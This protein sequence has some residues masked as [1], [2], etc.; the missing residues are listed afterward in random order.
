[1]ADFHF[2]I[3]S[4]I[5]MTSQD[6]CFPKSIAKPPQKK[7]RSYTL[8]HLS[9]V[10][11]ALEEICISCK[12]KLYWIEFSNGHG[13]FSNTGKLQE[14]RVAFKNSLRAYE[15]SDYQIKRKYIKKSNQFLIREGGNDD[16]FRT[17]RELSP[18]ERELVAPMITNQ[19]VD[20][21][22]SAKMLGGGPNSGQ[23]YREAID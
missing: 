2:N 22:N 8:R 13:G 11:M 23:K 21:T 6:I 15:P 18:L 4:L 5:I 10:R 20:V 12:Y 19:S 17:Q 14:Y 9:T 3:M 16:M 1:M 7:N